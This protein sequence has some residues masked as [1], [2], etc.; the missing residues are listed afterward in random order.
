M[1][2]DFKTITEKSLLNCHC[3]GVHSFVLN[4]RENGKL[5]RL[6]LT[7][8]DHELWMTDLRRDVDSST[9]SIAFHPH[10]RNLR[11]S[12]IKGKLYNAY[13]NIL[14]K[15]NLHGVP[16]KAWNYVS[17]IDGE[18][19]F[20][21]GGTI[22]YDNLSINWLTEGSSEYL[23]AKKVHTVWA[24][25]GEVVAWLIQEEDEDKTY[26]SRCFSSANLEE[27][28]WK[29]LY[30]KPTIEQTREMLT[31]YITQLDG[32]ILRK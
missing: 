12:V 1:S 2:F 7:T 26:D 18:G 13:I 15:G 25:K 16:I 10:R 4:E 22:Y 32:K 30:I 19:K 14:E 17:K 28:D 8:P 9:K 5:D 23:H 20:E 3:K 11:I 6:Y 27:F 31:P 21:R 24:E 29:G